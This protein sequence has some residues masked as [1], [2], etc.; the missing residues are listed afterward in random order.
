MRAFGLCFFLL[1]ALLSY[2]QTDTAR[3]VKSKSLLKYELQTL[4]NTQKAGKL[5]NLSDPAYNLLAVDTAT[6]T[7]LIEIITRISPAAMQT[8]LREA[9]IE[10]VSAYERMI[11]CRITPAQLAIINTLTG[12]RWVQPAY[13]PNHRRYTPLIG[14]NVIGQGYQA[15]RVDSLRKRTGLTG[16]G[17]KVG[18]LS[19]SYNA[20]NGAA[21]GVL[22]DE[23]PG[24]TNPNNFTTAVKV[25]RDYTASGATDE[26]RAMLEIVHDIAPA[27]ALY[28]HTAYSA[29]TTFAS[30]IQALADSGCK[31]II[32]DVSYFAQPY[33]QDGIIAQAVDKVKANQGVTYF[34]A[35]GNSATKSYEYAFQ[36][37]T[38]KPFSG[39]A[40]AQITAHN[41]AA[42]G[43]PAVYYL[44]ITI[45]AG[46]Q[47]I[48]GF[49]WSEPFASAIP[50][51]STSTAGATTDM[52]IYLLKSK[53]NGA[54][55]SDSNIIVA[56]GISDNI[57]TDPAELFSYF[58]PG[59]SATFYLLITRFTPR[60]NPARLK[61][62]GFSNFSFP[63]SASAL[64]GINA[65]TCFGHPNAAG[66]IAA[67]AASYDDT[68]AFGQS[69]PLLE[70]YSSKGGIPIYF[71]P[72]GSLYAAPVTR[73]KPEMVAPD[74]ANTSFFYG[75]YDYEKD[76]SPNFPGTSAAAPHA[77]AVAALLL[78]ARPKLTP[79]QL[80]MGLQTTAIDM[81]DPTTPG[82]DTGFDFG[83]GYGLIQAD[84]AYKNLA[85]AYPCATMASGSWNDATIWSCGV[86]PRVGDT[87]TINSGHVITIDGFTAQAAKLKYGV[88]GRLLF[89][90]NGRLRFTP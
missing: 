22:A 87:V 3:V 32:D 61:I 43:Q 83:S 21:A 19:D 17:I 4:Y 68:P 53:P 27:A 77:G 55:A 49:Q 40:N 1:S 89:Q 46:S 36:A 34:S 15:L 59:A 2:A 14:G 29:A 63:T 28:F 70:Y 76:G 71:Y 58:N 13:Q 56:Q 37:S 52:D 73:Q 45:G 12:Y 16:V 26:G 75:S 84:Q 5:I 24:T 82:F 11:T 47:M 66:A 88:S 51:S 65:S 50:A 38:Y 8:Q 79:D 7:L 44:P 35:A 72:D 78:Q 25:I 48:V 41:F 20:Q 39:T 23:L 67:G 60:G 42:S 86:V 62:I 30:G 85:L 90:H 9:G 54:I 64:P 18:V 6:N 80:K 10:V 57:G 81:D 33:F 74:N 69:P 31:I